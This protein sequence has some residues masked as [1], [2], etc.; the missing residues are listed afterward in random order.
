MGGLPGNKHLS[1]IKSREIQ[2]GRANQLRF[3][4]TRGQISAQLASDHAGSQ[5]NLG[6]LTQ[7]H[8]D[9]EGETRG[10]GAEL[11]SDQAVAL[12]AANGILL[13]A[14]ASPKDNQLDRKELLGMLDVLVNVADQLAFL[15]KTHSSDDADGQQLAQLA[16]KLNAWAPDVGTQAVIAASAPDGMAMISNENVVIGAQSKLDMISVDDAQIASGKN[17]LARAAHGLSLFAHKLGMK[18]VAA[19]GNVV[20]QT[21]HGDINLTATGRI[22]ITAGEG[23]EIQAPEVKIATK[24]AQANFGGGA[25]TQQC[26]GAHI[27][28]SATF[29]HTKGGN[30]SVSE[31]KFPS[32]KME[33]DERVILHHS[34]T[35]K[36]VAGRRYSLHLPDGSS[37]DG[38]T[39]ELGRTDLATSDEMGNIEIV[40]H[41]EDETGD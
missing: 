37:I 21:H 26:S 40:I 19:S 33:T 11:R 7:P 29:A 30:G 2:G 10:E 4:D 23:V 17:V 5:I 15:A 13:S 35:G 39:D 28:K 22:R 1:G 8:S 31:V 18:L 27:I 20:M 12:R 34:Q 41:P 38:V 25:I 36:P 9:G 6:F 32:T 16:K 24:G 3:D 14:A